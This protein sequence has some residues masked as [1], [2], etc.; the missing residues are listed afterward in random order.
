MTNLHNPETDNDP[1]EFVIEEYWVIA[2]FE[3][4]DE[5]HIGDVDLRADA[6]FQEMP[7]ELEING[8]T[9]KRED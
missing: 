3:D 1:R 9:Y 2:T 5:V 8:F 4:G 7:E 6:S